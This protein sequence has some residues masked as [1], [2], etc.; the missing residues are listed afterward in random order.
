M[1]NFWDFHAQIWQFWK[2]TCIS[3]TAARR[4]KISSISNPWGREKSIHLQLLEL[5][6][7]FMPFFYGNFE[8]WP[9][10]W[11]L[12]PI[13]QKLAQFWPP[14]VEK[15]LYVQLL[16]LSEIVYQTAIHFFQ[17]LGRNLKAAHHRAKHMKI[18]ALVCSMHVGIFDQAW[19]CQSHLRSFSALT[20]NWAVTQKWLIV[21]RNEQNFGSWRMYVALCFFFTLN[22]SRS[23]GVIQCTFPPPKK[24]QTNK[25][26]SNSKTAH[27]RAK[28]TTISALGVYVACMLVFLTLNMSRLFGVIRCTFPKIG[29]LL[30]MVHRRVKWTKFWALGVYVALCCCF[31][32]LEHIKVVWGPSVHFASQNGVTQKRLIVERNGQ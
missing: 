2:L 21:E 10:S 12:V 23:F 26:S 24:K 7:S 5:W 29:P 9:V 16:E 3:E 28:R 6:P 31:F 13:E 1:C 19:T 25:Q 15:Q 27:R 20:E 22:I 32:H 18:W 11:K 8:K 30:K 17:K 4:A 14:G